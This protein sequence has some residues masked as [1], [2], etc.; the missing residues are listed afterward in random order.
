[1]KKLFLLAIAAVLL[2]CALSMGVFA[3]D[4]VP[5][6]YVE[7]DNSYTVYTDIQYKTVTEGIRD[8]TLT[9]KTVVLG[10][11]IDCQTD[12]VLNVE[13]DI[14]IDLN[15]KFLNNVYVNNKSGDF[16]MQHEN[17]VIR[18]K[19]GRMYSNFCMFIF[20]TAGQVYL[21]DVE[22]VSREECFYQ[23]G[24][25]TGVIS[26]KSCSIDIEGNYSTI[27]LSSCSGKGGMLYQIEDCNLDGLNIH[28][29]KPGSFV[30][31]TVIYNR[32]LHVDCWHSHGENGADVV[33]TFTNVSA[34]AD[35]V[36]LND[37]RIDPEFYD[38]QLGGVHLTGSD[39][40]LAVYTSATCDTAGTKQEYKGSDTPV[41]DEQ[42]SIDNPALG[43]LI[44]VDDA[45]DIQYDS[46]FG[47]GYYTGKCGR[48]GV[49]NTRECKPSAQAFLVTQGFSVPEMGDISIAF[50]VLVNYGAIDRYEAVTGNFVELGMVAAIADKL[51]DNT[52][53][54]AQGKATV[55]ESGNVIKARLQRVNNYIDLK[56][57]GL[58]DEHKS[59]ALIMGGYVLVT[60]NEGAVQR[61]EYLQASEPLAGERYSSITYNSL[62]TK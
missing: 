4:T 52:L 46:L 49:E 14:T 39:K 57:G 1:M 10:C 23:Y 2:V 26:L 60:D 56:I 54:D 53:L 34:L 15:D 5:E 41:A 33:V 7:G 3:S 48:C 18:I 21:E 42:Y 59:L 32:R 6:N 29:A 58:K 61:I 24:G 27:A 36:E 51:G 47:E 9:N 22:I 28:C 50:S 40:Y 55:L 20:R 44:D 62:L 35:I 12:L 25:H 8:G 19:N 45:T 31:D 38:C 16:D 17:A 13:C 30:K 37:R 11:D 43:H